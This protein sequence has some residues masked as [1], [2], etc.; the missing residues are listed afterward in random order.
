MR[1]PAFIV[2]LSLAAGLVAC[3]S[4]DNESGTERPLSAVMSGSTRVPVRQLVRVDGS[5]STGPNDRTY[6]W[7]LVGRPDGSQAS[8]LD[9][10]SSR[11]EFL[12]DLAGT[13]EVRLVV[14]AGLISDEASLVMTAENFA[15]VA[16]AGPDR[17]VDVGNTVP[18]DGTSSR[19]DNGDAITY[20]WSLALPPGSSATLSDVTAS[21][22][23]FAADVTGNFFV[24]LV[25]NDGLVDSIA[26]RVVITARVPSGVDSGVTSDSGV[27][28]SNCGTSCV[29]TAAAPCN[30][31]CAS[32][33][34]S[35]S[36]G[37]G[38]TGSAS[39]SGG[40]C[41]FSVGSGASASVSCGGGGCSV[42]VGAGA[43]VAVDCPGGSCTVDCGQGAECDVNCP[44]GR[45]ETTCDLNSICRV[46]CDDP[47]VTASR[48]E[49]RCIMD[50]FSGPKFCEQVCERNCQVDC[51]G[52]ETCR[53]PECNTRDPLLLCLCS[54]CTE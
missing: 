5:R 37:S 48:D 24:D 22:P 31:T 11:T 12:A 19:D 35:V 13:Y 51:A 54:G 45:C 28:P 14:R 20:R 4:D 42:S 44:E 9:P 16:N 50:C 38:G 26:D 6:A 41:S 15:P 21:Q 17:T 46:D 34:C 18:V 36:I 52:V 30:A 53:Q 47:T 39:C 32:G 25:V 33:G 2:L 29:C 1:A 49:G 27:P 3:A 7:S 43:S 23:S 40:G 10:T 8:L